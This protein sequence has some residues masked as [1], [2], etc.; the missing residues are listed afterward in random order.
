MKGFVFIYGSE[1]ILRF[2][3]SGAFDALAAAHDLIYVLLRSDL[4]DSQ[5]A[6]EL[7]GRLPRVEWLPFYPGRFRRWEELFRIST[8]RYE[9]R[10][11]S[12]A[13]RHRQQAR[14]DPSLARLTRLAQPEVYE[15]HRQRVM[16]EMGL[17]PEML[18]LT[19]RERPDFFVLPSALLDYATDD[20]LQ[21][22]D[23]LSIP[24]LML[25]AGWDNLSSKGLINHQ[26]AM[27]GVWGQQSK[28]H[29]VAV[30]NADPARVHVV[31][32]P[33]YEYFRHPPP[34]DRAALCAEWGVPDDRTLVLLAGTFRTFDE[35]E[36][37]IELEEAI[38]AGELPPLHVIYRPHPWRTRR[39]SEADFFAS[40]WK[41]VT[42]DPQMTDAY[43][44]ARSK[45][46]ATGSRG[47]FFRM[48]HLARLYQLVEAVICPM[49]TV[50]LE[51]LLFKLPIM[52]VA[53]SDGKHRWSADKTAQMMH[54]QEFYE[55]P[56]LITCRAREDFLPGVRQLLAQ[57]GDDSIWAARRDR[58]DYF[59]HRD[60]QPYADKVAALVETM[61]ARSSPPAYDTAR[62]EPG[63]RY[64]ASYVRG[65]LLNS[66]AGRIVRQMARNV[67]SRVR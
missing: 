6:A 48:N 12:F 57:I 21:L 53:F 50:L 41:H 9:D 22:A 10:S 17:H 42:M 35:T 44:Q 62:V 16:Q 49:S 8:I 66:P 51:A 28:E 58:L 61:L 67:L 13:I 45:I 63:R 33:H 1:M 60:E 37:L 7:D 19:L 23:A 29:A 56:H 34:I 2:A 3:D 64:A 59:I 40:D 46:A 5:M 36:L 55:L 14:T 30:Q 31:G 32:A 11:P 25:V 54:F 20:V 65:R 43:R 52:A 39:T 24:T 15:A 47:F 27:M 26:P 4:I 18:A 38:A